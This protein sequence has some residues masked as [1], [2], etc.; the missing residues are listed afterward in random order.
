MSEPL[1]RVFD[2]YLKLTHKDEIT[3]LQRVIIT[4]QD[5][6]DE[7]NNGGL[8]LY[9]T[10]QTARDAHLIIPALTQ[11]GAHEMSQIVQK[12]F[13]LVFPDG[14]PASEQEIASI[15]FNRNPSIDINFG[16][17]IYKLHEYKI[18]GE[19]LETFI[20]RHPEEFEHL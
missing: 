11:I 20:K 15:A 2:I 12:G 3:E 5:F 7:V 16:G 1:E 17:A 10:N 6:L 14:L 4:V 18:L 13:D 8:G 9:L 19:L